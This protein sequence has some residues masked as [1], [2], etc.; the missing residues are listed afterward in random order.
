[1]LDFAS[2]LR[3][4]Q[5]ISGTIQ[6]D[7][8]LHQLPQ[9]ILQ[10]SGG[11]RCALILPD[12]Q[13]V[14]Q[15]RAIATAEQ[16]ELCLEPLEGNSKLPAKLIQYVKNTREVV[17]FENCETTLPVIDEYLDQRQPKSILC[18]P[19]INQGTLLGIVYLKNQVTTGVFTKDRILI[20]NFLCV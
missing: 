8:L 6:L 12:D 18:L 19:I 1:M 10:N 3:A 7:Q 17:A 11:D 14:W 20:L 9:I 13:G 15:I 5:A 4:S 2:I 16:S